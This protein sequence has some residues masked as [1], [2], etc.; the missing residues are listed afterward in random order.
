MTENGHSK[1]I[2]NSRG[3]LF[4]TGYLAIFVFMAITL[5]TVDKI[6]IHLAIN[7]FHNPFL[8]SLM[9]Y[10]TYLG[11]GLLVAILV[12]GLL[13]VSFRIFFIGLAASVIGGVGA[14][15]LKR[16]FF[17]HAARPVKFF[18]LNGSADLLYLVPGTEVHNWYSFPSGHTATAFAVMFA[19]ALTTRSRWLQM[20]LLILAIGVGYSRMYLSMH[21]MVDVLGGSILGMLSGYLAWRWIHRY[22]S[23]WFD[24]SILNF[25]R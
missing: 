21:F 19:L 10:W 24:K 20:L 8:D 9:K 3:V 18:E 7:R 13:M 17:E 15:I 22:Q 11:D 5:L 2:F 25:R 4:L 6:S 16:L 23:E 14:Q 12:I 1:S